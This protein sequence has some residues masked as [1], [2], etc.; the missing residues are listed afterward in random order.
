MCGSCVAIPCK[1]DVGVGRVEAWIGVV[2][3]EGTSTLSFWSS[4]RFAFRSLL[5]GEEECDPDSIG[6]MKRGQRRRATERKERMSRP[7]CL[8][9]VSHITEQY[10][11]HTSFVSFVL[12]GRVGFGSVRA[13]ICIIS[14][15]M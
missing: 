1:A 5:K 3:R 15:L 14:D 12:C 2:R 8:H 11:L 7:E 10:L 13:I 9:S 4:D 6:A